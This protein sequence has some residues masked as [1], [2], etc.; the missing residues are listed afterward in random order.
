LQPGTGANRGWGCYLDTATTGSIH[1]TYIIN[2]PELF[3]SG[4]AVGVHTLDVGKQFLGMPSASTVATLGPN[5]IVHNW[6]EWSADG[7]GSPNFVN[8]AGN[9]APAAT[10]NYTGLVV[11]PGVTGVAGVTAVEPKYVDD[12]RTSSSYAKTLGITG[13]NDGPTLLQRMSQQRSTNWDVR[14]EASAVFDFIEAGFQV[15]A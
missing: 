7:K 13:V 2:K 1:D 5:L 12:T 6:K 15:A 9:N 3:N 14:L 11:L 4:L 10:I 8:L